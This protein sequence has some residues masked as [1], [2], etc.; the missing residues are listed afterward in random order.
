MT[1][2]DWTA[3]EYHRTLLGGYGSMPDGLYTASPEAVG[4]LYYHPN[5]TLA[6]IKFRFSDEAARRLGRRFSDDQSRSSKG[7]AVL[8]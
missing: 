7:P 4:I 8:R 2:D 6:T 5:G 3:E 1:G